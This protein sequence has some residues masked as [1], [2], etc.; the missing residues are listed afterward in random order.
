MKFDELLQ[1]VNVL[2]GEMS[3]V[4]PRPQLRREAALYTPVERKLF[5]VRP[6]ITD[7]SSIVFSD[8]ERI[9]APEPDPDIAYNQLVRPWKSR[10]GLVYVE[11][12]SLA[13]DVAVIAL[14]VL[15]AVWRRGTLMLISAILRR[16]DADPEVA[17]VA[18]R[19]RKLTPAPPPGSD[20]IVTSRVPAAV[21]G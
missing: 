17:A 5:N 7:F 9:V 11:K 8:L 3:V 6:G 21:K 19:E 1:F 4:G 13:V 18:R 20:A 14:T 10:L 12:H 16:L 15:N 2:K